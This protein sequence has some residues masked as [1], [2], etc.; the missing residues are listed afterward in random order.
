[1]SPC[2]TAVTVVRAL[3]ESAYAQS[4]RAW[5]CCNSGPSVQQSTHAL[6][7]RAWL[8]CNCG[9][10]T[11]RKCQCKQ[12]VHHACVH[13]YAATVDH[14]QAAKCLCAM[15]P[16]MTVLSLCCMQESACPPWEHVESCTQLRAVRSPRPALWRHMQMCPRTELLWEILPM[17]QR[18][19]VV[20]L[21]STMQHIVRS[22]INYGSWCYAIL[23]LYLYLVWWVIKW[24]MCQAAD[25]M[26]LCDVK[27][28]DCLSCR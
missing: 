10:C 14:V 3:Q 18:L 15:S 4:V 12:P 7:V 22:V 5:L 21:Y 25:V 27:I 16:C 20:G 17:Q 6:W 19:Y 13:D 2:M 24:V 26:I 8:C 1:M 11:A 23:M 28:D 9:L